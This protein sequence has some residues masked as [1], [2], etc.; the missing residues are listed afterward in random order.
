VNF[1]CLLEMVENCFSY[2][3]NLPRVGYFFAK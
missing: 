1:L 3:E 2:P